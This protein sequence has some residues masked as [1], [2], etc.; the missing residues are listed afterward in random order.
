MDHSRYKRYKDLNLHA[1]DTDRG[2]LQINKATSINPV[3][4]EVVRKE[5]LK[6]LD[7]GIIYPVS[8]S[9]WVSSVQVILKKGGITVI[10]NDNNELIPIRTTTGWRVCMGYR[11]LNQATKKDN[12]SLPFIDQILERLAGHAFYY[13]LD[14]Y[15]GYN[16]I[17]IALEDQEKMT[18]TCPYGTSAYRKMT[19][20]LCNVPATFQDAC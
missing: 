16:Q 15:P 14:R 3:L 2:E 10:K 8:D 4:Q 20:D 18:F 11:K 7:V 1:Q 12:F 5:V 17:A 6:L 9:A 13:F 19:F